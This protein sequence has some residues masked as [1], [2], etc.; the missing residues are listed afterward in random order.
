MAKSSDAYSN[1]NPVDAIHRKGRIAGTLNRSAIT[2]LI[3]AYSEIYE[4][5]MDALL[6]SIRKGIIQVNERG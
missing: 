5:S 1:L 3:G 4:D 6:E 2:L